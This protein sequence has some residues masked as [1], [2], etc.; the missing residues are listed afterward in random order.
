[1]EKKVKLQDII[2]GIEMQFEEINTYL[3]LKTRQVIAVSTDSLWRAEEDEPFDDLPKWQQ[4][5]VKVAID[6]I[7]NFENYEK[8]PSQFEI[9]EYGM[10]ED[11]CYSIQ[12]NKHRNLLLGAIRGKGAFRRFKDLIIQ[13]NLE[14]D[15]YYYRDK[16]YRELAIDWCKTRGIDFTE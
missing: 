14:K 7:E 15:W 16:R 2:E 11:F 1:M 5:E 8:L 12:N 13:L 10:M 3:N 6:I 4:D 9:N